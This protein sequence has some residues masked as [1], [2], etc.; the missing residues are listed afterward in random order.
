MVLLAIVESL[1]SMKH[2]IAYIFLVLLGCPIFSQA[3]LQLASPFSDNM[4]LQRNQTIIIWGKGN[5][6]E[7]I[8][9]GLGFLAAATK[10]QVN[11]S[12]QI[13]FPAQAA[14]VTPLQL[15]LVMGEEKLQ[16][17]NILIGDV[18]LCIGQSN[19]EW[20]MSRELHWKTEQQQANQ[21]LI[22]FLNPPPAGRYVYNVKFKDS[23]LQRLNEEKFYQW[24]GWKTTS[25]STVA[26]MSAVAYYFAKRIQQDVKVPIGLINLSIGGAPLESF[27][28]TDALS[29]DPG[30]KQKVNGNWMYNDALPV[31]IRQRG[32]Q[33]LDSVPFI[34]G[35]ENGP[36]HA[37]KP[38]FAY[39]SGILPL[40]DFPISGV[41]VYQGESNAEEKE[42]VDEYGKLFSVMVEQ[43]RN[44]WSRP[45]L[46][47]YWVQL[48][49]IERPLWP[50]FRDEQRKLL[51]QI[52]NTGMAV[53]TDYGLRNDVH[54]P[55]KKI[56]GERLALWALRD[57]YAQ[58]IIPSG[59]LAVAATYKRNKV[60]VSFKNADGLKT[61]DGA[62]L[63]EI[64]IDGIA[65]RNITI[66]KNKLSV[67]VDKKPQV[68]SYGWKPY[69]EG[70]LVNK[71][72][73][74][75]STFYL[76]ID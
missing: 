13:Q 57:V 55:N 14:T 12:W 53:T 18:W 74:P 71:A 65:S 75:A 17:N 42:R 23:L 63:R 30:F 33:N 34:Y 46:P 60:I 27:I 59:P 70:N 7:K 41:L 56:V 40:K 44:N 51:E 64:A 49:S 58:K 67:A 76:K 1:S 5:P 43:Y 20:P 48:S 66:K 3:Q 69:S 72:G 45:T 11:G 24:D 16:F 22:R 36:H 31:W 32:L 26:S 10:V 21:P 29:A 4:V 9:A 47:V 6:G 35:D 62:P 61:S 25:A 68:V 28:G 19:M 15:S 73:L 8:D 38:G 2:V 37:F 54:P 52:P 39:K 50:A